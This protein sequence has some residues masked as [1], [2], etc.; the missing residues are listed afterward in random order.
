MDDRLKETLSAMLDDQA[1]E[2][3]VRRVLSHTEQQQ[4]RSQWQRWHQLREL[5]HE[6]QGRVEPIDVSHRVRQSLAGTGLTVDLPQPEPEPR[7]PTNWH[8]P[9]V[10][11]V[12][13]GLLVGFGMGTGWDIQQAE[14]PVLAR[15]ARLGPAETAGATSAEVMP[16]IALQGLDEQQWEHLSRYLLEHAQHN[17]VAA[18]RGAVGYARLASVSTPAY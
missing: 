8:W 10:A 11:M 1:D 2:L 3:S 15:E 6:G 5:L 16:E 7:E 14:S 4:V 9:A 17:S 18:G 13:A 12:M